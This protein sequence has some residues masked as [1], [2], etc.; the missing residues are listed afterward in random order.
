MT[1]LEDVVE[2]A[3]RRGFFWPAFSIYGGEAGYY[4]YAPLGVLLRDNILRVWKDHFAMEG[5]I[6]VDTPVVVPEPV[7]RASGHL[8]KFSDLAAEC[9]SCK[10]KQKLENFVEANGYHETLKTRD[11]ALA[12]LSDHTVKCPNC[13]TRITDA[14]DFNLMYRVEGT[15][16]RP[17]YLRPETAQGIFVNFRLLSNVFRGKLPMAVAQF[18]KGFRNEIS[19]RQ[20]LIRLREFYQGEV[21][22]FVD[23]EMKFWK[24]FKSDEVI[25]F[26]PRDGQER[27]MT[28][29]EALERGIV[30]SNAMAFFINKTHEILTTVGVD[31]K[32]LRF[33]QQRKDEL[34]HYSFDSW[35]AEALLDDAWVEIV[36]IADRNDLK[37]HQEASGQKFALSYNGREIIPSVIE[38]SYGI[39]RITL[40]VLIHSLGVNSKGFKVLSLRDEVAPYHMAVLPLVNRDGIDDYAAKLFK[41]ILQ[42][43]PYVYYDDSGSIGKRYARQDEIGTPYCLTVDYDTIADNTVTVR[44]RDSGKQVRIEAGIVEKDGLAGIRKLRE[45]A[46]SS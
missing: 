40:T 19:P 20:A 9:P 34:A 46:I 12:F 15:S 11:E 3:K 7:F 13:G 37:N 29:Y 30:S 39:D 42:K 24:D 14:F 35:D 25:R 31:P 21:E 41:S 22:V 28:A 27:E 2:L 4:D 6:F 32:R 18:G 17:L 44:F 16:S 36:G 1:L 33:R 26:L 8:Q 43:D 5:T 38:P 23:P 10:L 45:E